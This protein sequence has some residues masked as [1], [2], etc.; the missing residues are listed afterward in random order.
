MTKRVDKQQMSLDDYGK[1]KM[2]KFNC[3]AREVLLPVAPTKGTQQQE[4][5]HPNQKADA[6]EFSQQQRNQYEYNYDLNQ[7]SSAT[8]GP[9]VD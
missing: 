4:D 6:S 3:F 9:T 5:W 8:Q 7:M 1:W 2:N